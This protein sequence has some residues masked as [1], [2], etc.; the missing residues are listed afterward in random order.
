MSILFVLCAVL[1]LLPTTAFAAEWPETPF[2]RPDG[3]YWIEA[4]NPAVTVGFAGGISSLARA[5][6]KWTYQTPTWSITCNA[7]ST[8]KKFTTEG[9]HIMLWMSKDKVPNAYSI[10]WV[11]RTRR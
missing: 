11:T 2:T 1:T 8:F 7:T 3:W 10:S 4:H 5:A 6:R 9:T